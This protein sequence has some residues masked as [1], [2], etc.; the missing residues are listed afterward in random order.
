MYFFT[1]GANHRVHSICFLIWTQFFFSG[2]IWTSRDPK[3]PGIEYLPG[4]YTVIRINMG[5]FHEKADKDFLR[6]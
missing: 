1:V 3:I 6:F 4:I 5:D 2:F